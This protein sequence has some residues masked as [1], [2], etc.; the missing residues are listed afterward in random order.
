MSK[1]GFREGAWKPI[2]RDGSS[3][4]RVSSGE[5]SGKFLA[6]KK[7]NRRRVRDRNYSLRLPCTYYIIYR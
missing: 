6:R 3:E 5:E 4:E 7:K 1:G 2:N